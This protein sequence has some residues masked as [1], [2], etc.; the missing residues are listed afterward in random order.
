MEEGLRHSSLAGVVGETA[1]L[2]LTPSRRLQLSAGASGVPAFALR[3]GLAHPEPTAAHARW[4]ISAAPSAALPAQGLGR[5]QWRIELV[6]CRGAEPRAWL[7]EAPDAE[8]RLAPPP[9][10]ADGS[11]APQRARRASTS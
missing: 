6:R 7:L 9:D 10:L 1:R 2:G 8:G 3:R 11:R 4:R 5:G